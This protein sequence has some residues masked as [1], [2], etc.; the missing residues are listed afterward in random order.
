M[1]RHVCITVVATRRT[2]NR[3][4]SRPAPTLARVSNPADN[5]YAALRRLADRGREVEHR[6]PP[7]PYPRASG[8][9][10]SLEELRQRRDDVTRVAARHGAR[11]L[12]VYG[13]VV[14]GD[15]RPGSDVDV[16][17]EMGIR[18]GL[19]DQAALQRDLEELLG[20]PV[21]VVTVSGLSQADELTRER[22]EREAVSL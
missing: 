7:D 9:A 5:E 1:S 12:R 18:R 14:R 21:D 11:T 4:L 17:V 8:P 15:E 20:C 2:P 3:A 13:S 6:R 19:F 22:I 16:L 10:P